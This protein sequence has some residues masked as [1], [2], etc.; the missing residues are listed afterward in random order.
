MEQDAIDNPITKLPF[1][2]KYKVLQP[3]TGDR[4]VA[5]NDNIDL[6][7]SVNRLGGGYMYSRGFGFEKIDGGN[8]KMISD[9]G[10]DSIR[11]QL[12]TREVPIGIQEALVGMKK[13]ER[14]RVEL[15]PNV[16]FA[17]SNWQPEPTTKR[18]QATLAGYKRVLEGNGTNQPPFP[19]LSIW[20]VEVLRIRK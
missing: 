11:V 15:P 16:G 12:G 7:F 13:G 5:E 10:L 1:G 18:G 2:V 20:D 4:I 9:A 8:G 14:R 3:G 19:A 6:I 17:T